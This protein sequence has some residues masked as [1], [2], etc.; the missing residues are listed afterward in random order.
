MTYLYTRTGPNIKFLPTADRENEKY[1]SLLSKCKKKKKSIILIFNNKIEMQFNLIIQET[2]IYQIAFTNR[3]VYK[4][5]L[6]DCL[7]ICIHV[8]LYMYTS[9]LKIR[10]FRNIFMNTI[11]TKTTGNTFITHSYNR[12]ITSDSP[13]KCV[14]AIFQAHD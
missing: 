4:V 9:R 14:L 13:M 11:D 12:Y 2:L 1:Q 3:K 10:I 5:K 7:N 8:L 6:R